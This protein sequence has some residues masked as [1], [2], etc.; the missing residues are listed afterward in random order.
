MCGPFFPSAEQK[1][2]ALYQPTL[3]RKQFLKL[4]L[5][6]GGPGTN[7]AF[8]FVAKPP[9]K[10]SCTELSIRVGFEQSDMEPVDDCHP[11]YQ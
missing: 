11:H 5:V 1:A 9:R 7:G 4:I 2:F 3:I 6:T 8:F 10:G